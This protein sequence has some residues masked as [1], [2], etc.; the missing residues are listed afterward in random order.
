MGSRCG[1]SQADVYDDHDKP[2]LRAGEANAA[3]KEADSIYDGVAHLLRAAPSAGPFVYGAGARA[4]TI[5]QS[6]LLD[7]ERPSG[8]VTVVARTDE[9][10]RSMVI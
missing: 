10:I 3:C 6:P 4:A 7:M 8:T 9:C 2:W 1:F 5:S